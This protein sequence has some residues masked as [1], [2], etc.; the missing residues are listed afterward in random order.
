MSE[1][2]ELPGS[3]L[4]RRLEIYGTAAKV[5]GRYGRLKLPVGAPPKAV[6]ARYIEAC[7]RRGARDLYRAAVHL[8]G[9]FL[10]LGQFVSARP[11]L[12]PEAY[13]TELSKLQDRVP[14]APASVV[15]RVI[16]EDVG[17]VE[18]LFASFDADS[19][20]AASLAQVHRAVRHDGRAVAVKVQYPHVAEIVPEE[21]KDTVRILRLA[22]RFLAGVDLRTIS[23][24]LRRV[25]LEELDYVNEAAN[26]ERFAA[27]FADEPSIEVPGLHRDLSRGRVLVMDW[28]E[29]ENL[30]RALREADHETAEEAAR[31][32]VDSYLKQILVDG[33]LHADP[34]PGNFL[35]QPGPKLGFVDFGA[36]AAISEAT[37]H[38]LRDLYRSGLEQDPAMA[39]QALDALGFRTRS[40]DV[41]SLVAWVSL[42]DSSEVD[43]NREAAWSKLMAAAREDPVVK[44]PD[45]LIMVGRVLMVQTGLV[46]RIKPSW[47]MA[48]LL[49]ARLGPA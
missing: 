23:G 37:R 40:G 35:L 24:A 7:H 34:H 15:R 22:D 13:V 32:L 43:E 33:F 14:P 25:V 17:P 26:L 12:L 21:M 38:G 4:S 18:E 29:G 41:S 19:A 11:D 30:G 39:G 46:A 2:W 6:R 28:V 42:F 36:C 1:E 48:D 9:G 16:E 5:G 8:R 49:A 44:L 27:N 10:K 45:E 47:S 20:S 3:R 31:L